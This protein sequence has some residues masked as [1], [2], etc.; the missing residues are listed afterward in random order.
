MFILRI[1]TCRMGRGV[2]LVNLLHKIPY[3]NQVWQ[4]SVQVGLEKG[5]ET[6]L[7]LDQRIV[8]VSPRP[9]DGGP[10]FPNDYIAK[11]CMAVGSLWRI[12]LNC[13]KYVHYHKGKKGR[14]QNC[15]P[16][17][18][19]SLRKVSLGPIIINNQVLP[20]INSTFSWQNWAFS[21]RN[22]NGT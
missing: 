14:I 22:F 7:K 1:L 4:D 15:R 16:F 3:W 13:K 18:V 9:G 10:V 19:S 21:N 5:S 2:V 6:Q 17:L 8:F 12:I 20:K 11:I